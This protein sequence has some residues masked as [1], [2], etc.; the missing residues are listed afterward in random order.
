MPGEARSGS[1]VDP[2]PYFAANASSAATATPGSFGVVVSNN[3]IGRTLPACN[4]TVTAPVTYAKWSDY[5]FGRMFTRNGYLDPSLAENDMRDHAVV[6]SDGVI[7]DVLVSGN[8]IRGMSSGLAL[9]QAQRMDNIVYRGNQVV[10]C[11]SYGVVVNNTGTMR[12]YI[13]ENLFDL[14]PFMKH[15]NRGPNGTW[16]AAGDPTGIKAQAGSGVMVRRNIFRNLCRDSDKASDASVTTWLFE[17]NIVEADPVSQGFST[18]NKGIGLMRSSAGTLLSQA[19]SNPASSTFG[20]ILTMPVQAAGTMPSSGK[21]LTGHFVRNS[22]VAI[23]GG[24][25]NLGW[26]RITTGSNNVLATDWAPA[27]AVGGPVNGPQV[28]AG[29]ASGTAIPG[30]RSLSFADV[31]GAAPAPSITN[32]YTAAGAIAV[33]DNLALVNAAAAVSMTLGSGTVDGHPIV[34]KRF[35]AGSVTVTAT[36]DGVAGS[37][38]VMNSTTIKESV[39]LAWSS[40]LATWLLY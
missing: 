40:A 37:R 23:T 31:A 20:Q 1:V 32:T 4:G 7:R 22:V 10:D 8:I 18:A 19:D 3:F 35:G 28:L 33:T 14:D 6:I 9:L 21:W 12:A 39:S 16:L 26:T 25:I 38:V 34:I 24:L 29:P 27:L 11:L 13:E 2:Y 36:I 5:G 30:F 15:P 17:N